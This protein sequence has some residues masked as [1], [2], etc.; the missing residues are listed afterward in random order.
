MVH[1]DWFHHLSLFDTGTTHS[2][3]FHLGRRKIMHCVITAL[4]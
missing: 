1:T 4:G 3:V 2:T